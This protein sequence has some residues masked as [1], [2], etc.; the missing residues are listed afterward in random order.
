MSSRYICGHRSIRVLGA[1]VPV[2]PITRL[3]RG[4]TFLSALNRCAL[5]DLK[6]DSSSITSASKRHV[7]CSTSQLTFSRLMI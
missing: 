5:A 2:S 3:H 6:E 7:V 1:G 4:R